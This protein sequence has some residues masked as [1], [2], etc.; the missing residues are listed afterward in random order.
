V[1]VVVVVAVVLPLLLPP[2]V[3]HTVPRET[4]MGGYH[5]R[6]K[7][8]WKVSALRNFGSGERVGPYDVFGLGSRRP[9]ASTGLRNSLPGWRV[10]PWS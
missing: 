4:G 8:P 7:W 2:V 9:S 5:M 6:T 1:V 3:L 10:G